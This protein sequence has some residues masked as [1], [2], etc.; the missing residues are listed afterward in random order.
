MIPITRVCGRL[1]SYTAVRRRSSPA[2]T[3]IPSGLWKLDI[4]VGPGSCSSGSGIGPFQLGWEV[5]SVRPQVWSESAS[6]IPPPCMCPPAV[7]SRPLSGMVRS[8]RRE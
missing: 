1:L 4:L 3:G 2:A 6:L 8:T 5:K 7:R